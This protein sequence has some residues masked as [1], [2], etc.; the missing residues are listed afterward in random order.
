MGVHL[1]SLFLVASSYF[2]TAAPDRVGLDSA[3]RPVDA[4]DLFDVDLLV[5]MLRAIVRGYRRGFVGAGSDEALPFDPQAAAAAMI[6]AMGVDRHMEEILRVVDQQHMTRAVFE[7]FLMRRGWTR[8]RASAT[9]QGQADLILQT[10]PHL[11][12]FNQAISLPELIRITGATA[13]DCV[14]RRFRRERLAVGNN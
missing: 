6:E 11:G 9:P 3:G 5:R 10:G 12:G 4:R 2:R 14:L 7:A 13:A 8:T 1:L